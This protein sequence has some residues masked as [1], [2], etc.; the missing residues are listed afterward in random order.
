MTASVSVRT[1]SGSALV[2]T[3]FCITHRTDS[4]VCAAVW[5]SLV[6]RFRV[7]CRRDDHR[8]V[9]PNSS[10]QAVLV[11]PV[12]RTTGPGKDVMTAS[13]SVRTA[14]GSALV[15][16]RF[17]VTYSTDPDVCTALW[18]SLVRRFGVACRRDG[19]RSLTPDSSQQAILVRSARPVPCRRTDATVPFLTDRSPSYLRGEWRGFGGEI[20]NGQVRWQD[21]NREVCGGTV[22]LFATE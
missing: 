12:R 5:R 16:T 20:R 17:S 3:R 10:Q 13:V 21:K 15:G 11:W 2:R 19:H 18:R 1:A 22:G 7:A 14:S 4:D 8:S 6:R 9:A